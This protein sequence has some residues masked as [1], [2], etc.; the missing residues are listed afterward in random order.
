[1]DQERA[2]DILEEMDPSAAADALEDLDEEIAEQLLAKMEPEE[3]ADVQASLAYD[4]DSVGRMM[5]HEFVRVPESATVGDAIRTIRELEEVPDPL[6]AVYV[7][8]DD[9]PDVLYGIIR[10]RS[11]ILEDPSTPLRDLAERNLPSVHPD[12]STEDVGLVLAE[13]NL[14]AAPVVDD[15]GH[16]I[17]IVTVDD[18]L[19]ALLP[20]VWERRGRAFS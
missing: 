3:A 1:M 16:M 4:E 11:L 13:Y 7:M 14:L 10:L 20:E 17:A 5:S 18:A 6:L 9:D 2:A 12:D 8:T 15:D 19:A